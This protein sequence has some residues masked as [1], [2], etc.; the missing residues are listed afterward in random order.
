LD[1]SDLSSRGK[2]NEQVAVA[3]SEAGFVGE[4]GKVGVASEAGFVGEVGKLG[5]ASEAG[6]E[7]TEAGMVRSLDARE[8]PS[9]IARHQGPAGFG[10]SFDRVLDI[11]LTHAKRFGKRETTLLVPAFNEWSEQVRGLHDC[12]P[13]LS[14]ARA[15]RITADSLDALTTD[16]WMRPL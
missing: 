10:T 1:R 5:A 14:C 4:V 3:A 6:F 7:A 12:I 15:L 11:S 9:F 8:S 13:S 16:G 2:A